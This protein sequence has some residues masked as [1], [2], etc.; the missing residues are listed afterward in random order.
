[1]EVPTYA[2]VAN[3]IS[4]ALKARN[5]GNFFNDSPTI[6]K[7]RKM[8]LPKPNLS[9][10]QEYIYCEKCNLNIYHTKYNLHNYKNKHVVHCNKKR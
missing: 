8:Y 2:S 7:V 5:N 10:E 9:E 1:M 6:E 3:S 4:E